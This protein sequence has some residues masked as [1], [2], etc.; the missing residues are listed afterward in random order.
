VFWSSVS[1]TDGPPKLPLL[2]EWIPLPTFDTS[3][4][5]TSVPTELFI[6]I[7]S[8]ACVT[9]FSAIVPEPPKLLMAIDA[10]SPSTLVT[11]LFRIENVPKFVPA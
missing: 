8:E 6:E 4:S 9:V 10:A 7:P 11:S 1:A 5:C 3:F 2:S